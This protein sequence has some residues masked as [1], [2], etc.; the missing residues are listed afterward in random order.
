M[1]KAKGMIDQMNKVAASR[2]KKEKPDADDKPGFDY[3]NPVV[4]PAK[5]NA[6]AT[7]YRMKQFKSVK[8]KGARMVDE[9]AEYRK[10]K[11]VK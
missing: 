1:A 8:P 4:D 11:G 6:M 2:G 3:S 9:Q 10:R 7:P 5:P